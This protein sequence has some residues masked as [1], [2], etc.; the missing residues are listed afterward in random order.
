MHFMNSEQL[1]AWAQNQN[2]PSI[3][4]VDN[5]VTNFTELNNLKEISAGRGFVIGDKTYI[6]QQDGTYKC[7][8]TTYTFDQLQR[9]LYNDQIVNNDPLNSG[10]RV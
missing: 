1:D 9:M 5:R 2:L 7:G 10:N 3:Q 4:F 8:E 6:K